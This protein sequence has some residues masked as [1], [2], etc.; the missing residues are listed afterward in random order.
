[1][2]NDVPERQRAPGEK[3][4]FTVP[5]APREQD[6]WH[7]ERGRDLY[8]RV[9]QRVNSASWEKLTPEQRTANIKADMEAAAQFADNRVRSRLGAKEVNRRIREGLNARGAA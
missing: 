1:L 8:R 6:A 3:D 2:P 4:T 9:E 7:E 5:L